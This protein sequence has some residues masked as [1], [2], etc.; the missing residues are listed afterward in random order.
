MNIAVFLG[1]FVSSPFFQSKQDLEKTLKR[2]L[3]RMLPIEMGSWAYRE[4]KGLK[5]LS[6]G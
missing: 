6:G 1:D 5:R 2:T 4:R 3:K